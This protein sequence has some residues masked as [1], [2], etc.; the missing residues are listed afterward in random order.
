MVKFTRI[1]F[2]KKYHIPLPLNH[3]YS[4]K[5]RQGKALIKEFTLTTEELNK[6]IYWLISNTAYFLMKI[7]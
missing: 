5:S 3:F 4:H 2:V 6:I 7:T 1:H